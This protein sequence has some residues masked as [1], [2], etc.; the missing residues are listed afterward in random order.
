MV[1]VSK[2]QEKK[3]KKS[4]ERDIVLRTAVVAMIAWMIFGGIVFAIGVMNPRE[5]PRAGLAKLEQMEEADTEEIDGQIQALEEAE[6]AA[7]EAWANRPVNEKYANSYVIGDSIAQGLYE[8]GILDG[9]YVTA[10]QDT[11]V[12]KSEVSMIEN[13]VSRAIEV[14]PQVLFLCY[15]LKDVEAASGNAQVFA[16]AYKNVL[17][18]LKSSLPETRIYV[19]SVLPVSQAVIDEN[20]LYG[21]IPDYNEELEKLCQEE[22]VTFI[23]N[24]SL[25]KDEYYMEDGIHMT[26]EY[27]TEWV[28]HMAEAAEL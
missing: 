3:T 17:D 20:E 19:N 25:V 26:S 22:E 2:K 24:S 18:T 11:G 21:S 10:E 12:C 5:D 7:D 13:H 23:D 4:E 16:M 28:N 1:T 9:T 14:S 27:Y 8:Q 15:G 6:R